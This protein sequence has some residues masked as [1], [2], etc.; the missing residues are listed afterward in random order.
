[1]NWESTI[2]LNVDVPTPRKNRPKYSPG[3]LVQIAVPRW[4]AGNSIRLNP[5]ELRPKVQD[6]YYLQAQV[7][8]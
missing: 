5:Q 4:Q 8:I 6:S 3:I 2:V 7:S 1:M